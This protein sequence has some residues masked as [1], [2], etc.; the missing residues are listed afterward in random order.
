[1]GKNNISNLIPVILVIGIIFTSYQSVNAAVRS[2]NSGDVLIWG[3]KSEQ[4]T[5]IIDFAENLTTFEIS[6]YICDT[7]LN[8]SSVEPFDKTYDAYITSTIGYI[9]Y[10]DVDYSWDN[11]ASNELVP[12]DF[13]NINYIWDYEH[14]RTV[15]D[16]FQLELGYE[17]LIEPDW[18]SLNDAF[19]DLFAEDI[20]I[21]TVNCPYN[22]TTYNLTVGTLF[23]NSEYNIMGEDN[24]S[25]ALPKF[26][27]TN[28]KWTISFNLSNY[29]MIENYNGSMLLYTPYDY[30]YQQI[31]LDFTEGG[32]LNCYRYTINSSI[33]IDGQQTNY[34]LDCME[35]LGGIDNLPDIGQTI[36][37]TAAFNGSIVAFIAV[38]SSSTMIII[39]KKRRKLSS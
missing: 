1:M 30:Y 24:I 19:D 12:D 25:N 39:V 13:Y 22:S 31:T 8:V 17:Y 4:I 7:K 21:D 11:F 2:W 36:T 10:P 26:T 20:I 15:C 5:Q 35:I 28:S 33:T 32:V 18:E 14:N 6:N 16:L 27:T 38:F 3:Q 9:F 23:A 37:V 29:V 34:L